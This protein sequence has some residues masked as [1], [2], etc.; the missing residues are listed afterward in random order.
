MERPARFDVD[1]ATREYLNQLNADGLLSPAEEDEIYDHFCSEI[2]HL[3]N[4]GLTGEEAFA[5]AQMRFGHSQTIRREFRKARPL[6]GIVPIMATATLLVLG[7]KS[8]I[9]LARILSTLVLMAG[10]AFS[11]AATEAYFTFGDWALQLGTIVG[12]T[13][14]GYLRLRKTKA[15]HIRHL[16][17]VPVVFILSEVA[18][19]GTMALTFDTEDIA[20]WTTHYI[21][22]EYVFLAVSGL[23]IATSLGVLYRHRHQKLQWI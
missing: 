22:S 1:L 18:A 19:R 2:S 12:L 6:A 10:Q 17:P 16:W 9:N 11:E 20:T 3:Q 14:V 23:V 8:M 15:T 21:N 7:I 5:V 4:S 13:G